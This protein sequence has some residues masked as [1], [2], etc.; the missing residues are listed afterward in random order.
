MK[1][2]IE[3]F[4][5]LLLL[6]AGG[7]RDRHADLR[8]VAR[9]V[10]GLHDTL[11]KGGVNPFAEVE[12]LSDRIVTLE[13]PEERDA[14]F[15]MLAESLYSFDLK[16]I[17]VD[18]SPHFGWCVRLM[19]YF[20]ESMM[21]AHRAMSHAEEYGI[22]IR[23]LA[24][25]RRQIQ[26]QSPAR[27]YPVGV[28]M[29]WTLSGEGHWDVRRKDYPQLRRYQCQMARYSKCVGEFDS[30]VEWCERTLDTDDY[31]FETKEELDA[32]REKL[33]AFLGRKL[34]TRKECDADTADGRR[35]D[36]PYLVPTPDGL[37]ECWTRDE[38]KRAKRRPGSSTAET[39]GAGVWQLNPS[40]P[41]ESVGTVCPQP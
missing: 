37:V 8:G 14:G 38:V 13:V 17:P 28:R 22:R 6:F 29:A 34:R 16:Q 25:L 9:D 10:A 2:G 26:S 12:R 20:A 32:A 18:D 31:D 15:D 1:R 35:R 24:W 3:L 11:L 21:Y 7:C 39:G 36:F 33:S 23:H 5:G 41:T 19:S 4:V 30:S 40:A 27:A